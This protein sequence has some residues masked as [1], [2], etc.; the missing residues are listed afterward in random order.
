MTFQSSRPV[1]G[2]T[3]LHWPTRSQRGKFQ[4]SRPVGGATISAL[5]C[6]ATTSD[7][8]PRAP[9]GARR[10]TGFMP[11]ITFSIS[12]L[13]PRGGRDVTAFSAWISPAI[14]QSSRPVGGATATASFPAICRIYFNP[15]APWGARLP[16]SGQP[17]HVQLISILAP[18]GG[19]D[20]HRAV[21]ISCCKQNFNPRAPWGARQQKCT[22][23]LAHFAIT[24]NLR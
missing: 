20:G 11:D 17:N 3:S 2:A 10:H 8:N 23:L 18:R 22:N 1:G 21:R 9:W 24:D 16:V 19:R 7:F 13:A 4:S 12:I 15:R 6:K 5:V 14:F